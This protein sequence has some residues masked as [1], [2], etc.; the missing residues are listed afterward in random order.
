MKITVAGGA[1][2][3]RLVRL[4]T[5]PRKPLTPTEGALS[6]LLER[7]EAGEA[8]GREGELAAEEGF[9]EGLTFRSW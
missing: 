3:M 7:S 6:T 8:R 9:D 5:L 4:D 2:A 1:G